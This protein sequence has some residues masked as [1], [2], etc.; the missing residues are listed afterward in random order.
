MENLTFEDIDTLELARQ[1]CLRDFRSFS[2]IQVRV[3]AIYTCDANVI[4]VLAE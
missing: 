3:C 4:L 2:A 1:I